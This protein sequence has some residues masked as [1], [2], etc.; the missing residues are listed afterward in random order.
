MNVKGCI[1]LV[2][3]K[4]KNLLSPS[5][6]ELYDPYNTISPHSEHDISQG[7]GHS[8]SLFR[9]EDNPEPQSIPINKSRWDVPAPA[10][11]PPERDDRGP[12]NGPRNSRARAT[13]PFVPGGYGSAGSS[14]DHRGGSPERH[15]LGVSPQRFPA[16]YRPKR[17]NDDERMISDYRGEVSA[18]ATFIY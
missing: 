13:E 4:K 12:D 7:Q 10:S 6:C 2:K 15:I 17:P 1:T 8:R 11:R 3:V 14:L 16:S 9:Q 5:R 18:T